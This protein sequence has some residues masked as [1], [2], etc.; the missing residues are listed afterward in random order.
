MAHLDGPRSGPSLRLPIDT[1][2]CPVD[3]QDHAQRGVEAGCVDA[4]HHMYL[5]GP[6]ASC[7]GG[8]PSGDRLITPMVCFTHLPPPPWALQIIW[9]GKEENTKGS[10]FTS[11]WQ[12]AKLCK[13]M[14]NKG[15]GCQHRKRIVIC[16]KGLGHDMGEV[17]G[18][19]LTQFK[20]INN[21]ETNGK[22]VKDKDPLWVGINFTTTLYC[23]YIIKMDFFLMVPI[24]P[25]KRKAG[26]RLSRRQ[27]EQ[28]GLGSRPG[29][30]IWWDTCPKCHNSAF[31]R[32]G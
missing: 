13:G 4:C 12:S 17:C 27:S 32:S 10:S 11:G 28:Q 30:E 2:R 9:D 19:C 14:G 21:M 8:G 18:S 5:E 6:E 7:S 26:E 22:Q 24:A 25:G 20:W 3:G 31:K 1:A 29:D 16:Q 15:K 23:Y